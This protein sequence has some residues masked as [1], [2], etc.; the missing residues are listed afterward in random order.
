ML[1]V[2]KYLGNDIIDFNTQPYNLGAGLYYGMYRGGSSNSPEDNTSD[3][4]Y[5]Q[6]IAGSKSNPLMFTLA[7]ASW[8]G[9]FYFR[10]IWGSNI[11]TWKKLA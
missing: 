9:T 4:T 8:G 6:V 3:G 10:Y 7:T 2:P 1:G 11:G 5:I